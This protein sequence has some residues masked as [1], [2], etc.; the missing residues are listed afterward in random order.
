MIEINQL[1]HYA[2]DDLSCNGDYYSIDL[3]VK[4]DGEVIFEK[5][6]GDSYHDKGRE[7]VEGVLGFIE[8]VFGIY[9][10]TKTSIADGE[11]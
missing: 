2:E 1:T 4:K 7:Q 11:F 3:E 5:R 10:L 6:Y 9:H 8:V